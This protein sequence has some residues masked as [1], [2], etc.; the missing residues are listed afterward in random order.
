MLPGHQSASGPD[1]GS[2]AASAAAAERPAPTARPRAKSA[3]RGLTWVYGGRRRGRAFLEPS[4]CP[5]PA[6][7]ALDWRPGQRDLAVGFLTRRLGVGTGSHLSTPASV[8]V[9]GLTDDFARALLP[10]RSHSPSG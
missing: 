6:W 2:D 9:N 3:L 4:L 7:W 1:R 10:Q 5:S 8:Q